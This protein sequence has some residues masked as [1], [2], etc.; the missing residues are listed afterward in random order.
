M[1]VNSDEEQVATSTLTAKNQITIPK[2]IRNFLGIKA[3][4][5]ISW[6]I[7]ENNTVVISTLHKE[8]WDIVDEQA[9]QYGSVDVSKFDWEDTKGE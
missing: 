3:T 9:K 6:K 1:W 7:R 4:D 2:I 8:L 5:M